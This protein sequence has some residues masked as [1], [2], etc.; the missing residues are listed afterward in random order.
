M[1]LARADRFADALAAGTLS[2]G[3]VL[4]VPSSGELPGVVAEEI[5]RL[6]PDEVVALG[7]AAAVGDDVLAQAADGRAGRRV[8][9]ENRYAT[10]VAIAERG[11]GDGADT[12][13]LAS[14]DDSP[15][16][17]AGGILTGGP[18]LLLPSNGD[19]LDEVTA[20]VDRLDPARVV[21]LG[22]TAAMTDAQLQ[23][24][25]GGRD[26]G[27]L[28]GATRF[29]TAAEI[30]RAEF[31]DEAGSV[32]VARADEFADAVA[33]GALTDGP[34]LLVPS[35]GDIPDEPRAYLEGVSTNRVLALGGEAAVCDHL[36]EDAADLPD[37]DLGGRQGAGTL[38][39]SQFWTLLQID[40]NEQ[41]L[42]KELFEDSRAD[43]KFRVVLDEREFAW[44]ERNITEPGVV[45]VQD[46]DD[47][48]LK[49]SFG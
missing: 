9:G 14:G 29:A 10:A 44:H 7:G 4:L 12:V 5:A 13:Y 31:G 45:F 8:A 40:M 32:Y 3:P 37:G 18:I 20:A 21:A 23:T 16:A 46:L 41:D 27:R 42:Q 36:L 34:V 22:G 38:Y 28:A 39:Y 48:S 11:F 47:N 17:V 49:T 25:A 1:Y 43:D 35:C 15:D 30:A 24:T 19:T 6:A 33:A 26:T 2:D